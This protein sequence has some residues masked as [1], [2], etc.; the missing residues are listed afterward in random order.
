MSEFLDGTMDGTIRHF[1]SALAKIAAGRLDNG[2]PL[3]GATAQDIARSCLFA[4]GTSWTGGVASSFSSRTAG[5]AALQ[6]EGE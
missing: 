6:R 4:T 1:E 2:R 3:G 5:R